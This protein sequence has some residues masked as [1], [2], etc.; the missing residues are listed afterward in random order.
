MATLAVARTPKRPRLPRL[1]K[2]DGWSERLIKLLSQWGWSKKD[3][4]RHIGVAEDDRNT[5]WRLFGGRGAV[6]RLAQL[7]REFE[8]STPEGMLSR[9]QTRLLRALEDLRRALE[10]RYE[11]RSPKASR[12]IEDSLNRFVEMIEG[13]VEAEVARHLAR[14]EG[15]DGDDGDDDERRPPVHRAPLAR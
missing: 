15:E 2:D 10:R 1:P 8:I 6:E 11:H 14:V 13:D 5:T 12:R 3:L 9:R 7:A 4:R